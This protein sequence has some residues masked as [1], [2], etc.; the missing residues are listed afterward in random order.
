M[1]SYGDAECHYDVQKGMVTFTERG[2]KKIIARF[3]SDAKAEAYLDHLVNGDP[4]PKKKSKKTSGKYE[5]KK[6]L[7]K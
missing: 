4:E 3:D 6:M 2:S 5:Q 7:H 1:K